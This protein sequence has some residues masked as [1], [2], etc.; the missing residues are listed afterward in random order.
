[1][2]IPRLLPPAAASLAALILVAPPSAWAWVPTGWSLDVTQR[3]VRVFNNFTDPEEDADRLFVFHR[4]V[5]KARDRL[6]Q[7]DTPAAR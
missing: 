5:E 4:D 6:R 3:D 2:K 7:G 1:M